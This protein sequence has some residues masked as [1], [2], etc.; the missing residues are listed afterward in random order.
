MMQI[1]HELGGIPLRQAYTL[2]KAISKKK[3]DVIA[4]NRERFLEGAQERGVDRRQAQELFELI[5]RFAG[6]GFNKSHSTAYAIVAYQT[7]YLKTYFPK[8]YMAA[9][10][11]YE[12]QAQKT[13]DWAPY[14]EDCRRTTL[15]NGGVGVEVRP[16]D[17]NRSEA[18]FTV[19]YDEDEPRDNVHGHVRFGLAAI[20]GVGVRAIETI[21]EERRRGGPF[22]SLFD[23]CERLEPGVVNKAALE[24][25]IKA[26][27]FDSVHGRDKRASLVATIDAAVAAGA[28]AAKDRAAGQGGL[29]ASEEIGDAASAATIPLVKT[30]PW[31]E[32]ETLRHEKE[33]VGLYLSS[34]PLQQRRELI[35]AFATASLQEVPERP[36]DARVVV[37]AIVQQARTPT[38]RAGERMAILTL[39][40]A[41]ATADAV[42]FPE[43][44]ARMGMWA[45]EGEAVFVVGTVDHRRGQGQIIVEELLPMD[46]AAER[47][48]A[49]VEIVLDE[50][51]INGASVEALQ[52][53]AGIIRSGRPAS[54]GG[55]K[56]AVRLVVRTHDRV[57]RLR[58]GA[59]AKVAPD[60]D[61]VRQVEQTLGEGAVRLVGAARS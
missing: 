1:V 3:E 54:E 20:R 29:F 51:K 14:L 46:K 13:A 30:A 21:V 58:P 34:H 55:R 37:A 18:A 10:L 4:A 32:A 47:L 25:L 56:A 59:W 5:L 52:W 48:A 12:S 22:T 17:I 24:A 2:I 60:A 50:R 39:E 57:V 11:T 9:F 49:A 43:V 27:A 7:A 45:Q 44:Y 36:Q 38:T 40:D 53:I 42:L 16:P 6:Y 41:Q 31:S 61:F 35:E 28:E 23:F 33:A 19:V 15:P 26:G 8:H